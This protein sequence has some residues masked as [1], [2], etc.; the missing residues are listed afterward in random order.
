MDLK[1]D[2]ERRVR[3]ALVDR[4]DLEEKRMFRGIAFMV[5]DKMCVN[6]VKDGLMCRVDPERHD[7]LVQLHG[8]KSLQMK[9]KDCKGYIDVSHEVLIS[10]EQLDFWL[11][12]CL[13]FNNRAKRSPKRKK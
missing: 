10:D 6:V 8:C 2:L 13:D 11:E 3:E 7:E 4:V 1:T 9:G 12:L 5:N